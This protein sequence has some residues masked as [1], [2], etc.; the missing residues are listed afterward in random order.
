MKSFSCHLDEYRDKKYMDGTIGG[1]GLEGKGGKRGSAREGSSFQMPRGG[2][3]FLLPEG[4]GRG[5]FSVKI[6][7]RQ[8]P[9]FLEVLFAPSV[10]LSIFLK[11]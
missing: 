9:K 6:S 5:V 11:T 10:E 2:S 7:G 3:S 8:R 4:G 1:H